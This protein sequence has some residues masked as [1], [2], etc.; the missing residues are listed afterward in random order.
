MI[1][2]STFSFVLYSDRVYISSSI[3]FL[4]FFAIFICVLSSMSFG[5][6]EKPSLAI[7]NMK[8]E[9]IEDSKVLSV[10]GSIVDGIYKLGTYMLIEQSEIAKYLSQK[11]LFIKGPLDNG[12]AVKAAKSANAQFL[13]ITLLSIKRGMYYLSMKL[14]NANTGKTVRI[15]KG[16]TDFGKVAGL[17]DEL[18]KRLLVPKKAT[19]VEVAKQEPIEETAAKAPFKGKGFFMA[20]GLDCFAPIPVGDAAT[21]L[22]MTIAPGI[23]FDLYF[24]F[25]W[26]IISAGMEGAFD[27]FGVKGFPNYYVI[28]VPIAVKADYIFPLN[29]FYLFGGIKAGTIVTNYKTFNLNEQRTGF[30]VY[31]APELGTGYIFAGFLGISLGA[32]LDMSIFSNWDLHMNISPFIR[33]SY[34]F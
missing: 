5:Q 8:P 34:L 14:I 2:A 7:I 32:S 1:K 22:N 24:A 19:K 33:V 11:E 20:A 4:F 3:R 6:S 28:D 9:N 30:V 21:F 29:D 13:L 12:T 27:Y 17:S 10:Y 18:A 23:F 31:I 15:V 16:T 26:G 25:D